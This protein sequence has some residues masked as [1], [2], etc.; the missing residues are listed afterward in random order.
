MAARQKEGSDLKEDGLIPVPEGDFL[1]QERTVA[2]LIAADP[3]AAAIS[4]DEA[5][6]FYAVALIV[7]NIDPRTD[8]EIWHRLG[9]PV[10]LGKKQSVQRAKVAALRRWK[11][12]RGREIL[13]SQ[14]GDY[15]L[16]RCPCPATQP[17][18]W[19]D[20]YFGKAVAKEHDVA[21]LA[22][23]RRYLGREETVAEWV[24]TLREEYQRQYRIRVN[25]GRLS[26]RKLV[27]TDPE[28]ARFKQDAAAA[29]QAQLGPRGDLS[30]ELHA[31][32]R[33]SVSMRQ[34]VRRLERDRKRLREQTRHAQREAVASL[35]Q[36]RGE[37]A[38]ARRAL[39]ARR[40][41][42]ERELAAQARRFAA[43]F[44]L[45]QGRIV[46]ARADFIRSLAHLP[47]SAR[48]NVLKGRTFSVAGKG[49]DRQAC[50]LLVESFGGSVCAED[51]GKPL[52]AKDSFAAFT[53]ELRRQA[54]E[55]VLIKCDG[56][57]RRK[58]SHRGIAISGFQVFIG[59]EMLGEESRITSSGPL[60]GSLMAEYGAVVMALA[61]L[62]AADPPPGAR[63]EI[64]SD[65]KTML[66]R[67][68]QKY[69]VRRKLGC[70][71]LDKTARR[72]LTLLRQRGCDVRLRWVPRDEVYSADRLVAG[73]YRVRHR[74]HQPGTPMRF[75]VKAF[76]K[77]ALRRT[78]PQAPPQIRTGGFVLDEPGFLVAASAWDDGAT[79]R[80][81]DYAP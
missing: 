30:A 72:L 8:A 31:K 23:V 73:S 18:R 2:E 38:A 41:E 60:A 80:R 46:A 21:W 39:E 58:E 44:A 81:R 67:L 7:D 64:W 74:Y 13:L 63:L 70:V 33:M 12:P 51:E 57:Y 36:A 45:L 75:T 5:G 24:A 55:Q 47:A 56:L 9:I 53:G 71:T 3:A 76:L 79:E 65:C 22:Q 15:A 11:H 61:W 52:P 17:E 16:E 10:Y 1:T 49:P 14:F 48:L 78:K 32:N 42:Q 59:D 34:D 77:A 4:D 20:E 35:S 29:E 43:E 50:R 62:V 40:A 26:L 25:L 37:V 27:Y 19:T 54:L 68:K 6:A 69:P 28:P 66:R